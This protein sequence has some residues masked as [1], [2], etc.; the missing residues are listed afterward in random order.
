M[1]LKYAEDDGY[2]VP[3][4]QKSQDF[5]KYEGAYVFEPKYVRQMISDEVFALDFQSLYPSIIRSYNLAPYNCEITPDSEGS[6][7][8]VNFPESGKQIYGRILE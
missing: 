8:Y 1:V 6:D 7:I 2:I 4:K 5:G 3:A